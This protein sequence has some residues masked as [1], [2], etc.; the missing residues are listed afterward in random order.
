MLSRV[1][2]SLFWIGRM[3]DRAE[4]IARLA[5]AARRIEA[6]PG[7][8]PEPN[9]E[10]RSTLISAGLRDSDLVDLE[11]VSRAAKPIVDL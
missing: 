8:G 6:L 11:E 9:T 10:W 4:N 5:D 3:I 7:E 1:A 2:D